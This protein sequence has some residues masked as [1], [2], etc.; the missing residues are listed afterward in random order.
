M[1]A[2]LMIGLSVYLF[3]GAFMSMENQIVEAQT[4]PSTVPT[5]PV[6]PILPP[7]SPTVPQISP[8]ELESIRKAVAESVKS[9]TWKQSLAAS[10]IVA[11][12][13]LTGVYITNRNNAK[14]QMVSQKLERAKLLLSL[15]PLVQQEQKEPLLSQIFEITDPEVG[16][17]LLTKT[18]VAVASVGNMTGHASGTSSASGTATAIASQLTSLQVELYKTVNADGEGSK[19]K[20][21]ALSDTWLRNRVQYV[22]LSNGEN[23]GLAAAVSERLAVGFQPSKTEKLEIVGGSTYEC[24]V[25]ATDEAT[26]LVAFS[27]PYY[28]TSSRVTPSM[29]TKLPPANSFVYMLSP[30][31]PSGFYVTEYLGANEMILKLGSVPKEIQPGTLVYDAAGDAIGVLR[32]D[33]VA[34]EINYANAF[35]LKHKEAAYKAVGAYYGG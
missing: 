26:G 32:K 1:R 10:I 8:Q 3:L 35:M 16:K 28:A 6:Q 23:V 25:V 11:L 13:S 33:G 5:A 17:M 7:Q 30:T 14:S 34:V 20:D 9:T 19:F 24:I 21:A 2:G 4:Q 18:S 31:H 27:Y 29:A 12:I 22:L 15:Y